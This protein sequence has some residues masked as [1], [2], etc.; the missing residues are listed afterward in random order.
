[1]AVTMFVEIDKIPGNATERNHKDW[2]NIQSMSFEMERAVDMQDLGSNQRAHANTSFQKIEVTSQIGK[3]SNKLA[4][5]VA[6]GTVHPEIEL[7]VCRSGG[8]ESDGL[9]PFSIWK[10]KHA[11]IDK[12]SIGYNEDGIPEE[13]W[14]IAYTGVDH[15]YKDTDA[16]TGQ[17]SK[18]NNFKWNLRT[19]KSE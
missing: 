3:A 2:I 12:Y 14:T 4:L 9:K 19:G 16:K 8:N 11:I 18:E 10:F 7:H 17:L 1:M 6:N 13:T 5:C 15:E